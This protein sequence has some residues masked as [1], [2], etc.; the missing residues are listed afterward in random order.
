MGSSKKAK[1]KAIDKR[2]FDVDEQKLAADLQR[3]LKAP[4]VPLKKRSP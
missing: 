4:P 2:K 1:P 3:I